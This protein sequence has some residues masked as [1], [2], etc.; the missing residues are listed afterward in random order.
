MDHS[1]RASTLSALSARV[2]D[3][4]V[5]VALNQAYSYRVPRGMELK[6]GDVVLDV[7]FL[8]NPYFVEGLSAHTGDMLADPVRPPIVAGIWPLV[9]VRAYDERKVLPWPSS[10]WP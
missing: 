1:T 8:P 4:L 3:V 7:R 9:S 6:P 10:S 2:V 5:P